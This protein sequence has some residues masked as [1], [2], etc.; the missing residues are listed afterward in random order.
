M[1]VELASLGE[2]EPALARE[3]F[4]QRD[5]VFAHVYVGYRASDA[6]RR[7]A[8]PAPPE[9]CPLPAVAYSIERI[10]ARTQGAGSFAVGD[11]QRTWSEAEYGAAVDAVRAAIA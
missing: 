4:F 11:W 10:G 3:G 7:L 6:L 1:T 5:D 2:L 8:L 9:P